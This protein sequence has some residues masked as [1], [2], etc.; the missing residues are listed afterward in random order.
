MTLNNDT[1]L[2]TK[3]Y[4]QGLEFYAQGQYKEA[5]KEHTQAINLNPSNLD[6]LLDRSNAYCQIG[7]FKK[8]IENLNEQSL[9]LSNDAYYHHILG[10]AYFG[11]EEH[12]C[13]LSYFNQSI[14]IDPTN[15]LVYFARGLIHS[16]LGDYALAV[17]DLSIA[18]KELRSL[19]IQNELS[20]AYRNLGMTYWYQKEK[21]K[22]LYHLNRSILLNPNEPESYLYRGAL[23]A[24]MGHIENARKDYIQ[25]SQYAPFLSESFL[26]IGMLYKKIGEKEEALEFYNKAI[27]R[28]SDF[29]E[30]YLMRGFLKHE[31]KNTIEAIRDF[32]AVSRIYPLKDRESLASN[33][34][35]ESRY[36]VHFIYSCFG[37]IW[38]PSLILTRG[39]MKVGYDIESAIDDFKTA[40]KFI[41]LSSENYQLLFDLKTGLNT[42][43][44]QSLAIAYLY[45]G[46]YKKSLQ[47]FNC[48]IDI[49]PEYG[50][51]YYLRG[52]LLA[53]LNQNNQAIWDIQ[54]AI[55]IFSQQSNQLGCDLSINLLNELEQPSN[56]DI[57]SEL[58]KIYSIFE[59]VEKR[60]DDI[61]I[62]NS[63][64][65][66]DLKTL[67]NSFRNRQTEDSF[68]IDSL[69]VKS[70]NLMQRL[71]LLEESICDDI[72]EGF[73]NIK[74]LSDKLIDISKNLEE[75]QNPSVDFNQNLEHWLIELNS[76]INLK[77]PNT[78]LVVGRKGSKKILYEALELCRNQL[79]LVCPWLCETVIN[80]KMMHK[81]QLLLQKNVTI[82]IGW[83][84]PEDEVSK[85]KIRNRSITRNDFI[86][87]SARWKYSAISSLEKFEKGYPDQFKLTQPRGTHE[88]YLVC[89]HQF[90]MITSH[91][92]LTSGDS[93][94][95][96]EVGIRTTETHII[97]KLIQLFENP[98]Y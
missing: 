47:N 77:S 29:A 37:M 24:S 42:K 6:A 49:D 81:M 70:D 83:G 7:K 96:L 66:E 13:A 97:E 53:E 87:N 86:A 74:V 26:L 88:K 38:N 80:S 95:I 35:S 5:I 3:H 84:Y 54:K 2:S 41:S 18:L 58:Q 52:L 93:D 64:E 1:E 50:Y 19:D 36:F 59:Y 72:E 4:Q 56:I 44:F 76:K 51:S 11:L 60:F 94:P 14:K 39:L 89:D 21:G 63:N 25:S 69:E 27:E 91:N 33:F 31:M 23:Y 32:D 20:I 98:I 48:Y 90:A 12:D 71:I 40:T 10:S 30:A 46:D 16:I 73:S 22:A 78:T 8:A 17:E 65:L 43:G 34:N 9:L 15:P 85:Q 68:R 57:S 61:T 92:F 62:H 82:S 75:L 67:L 79:I 28:D 45:L 55:K